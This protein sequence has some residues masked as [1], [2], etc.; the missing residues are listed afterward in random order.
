MKLQPCHFLARLIK[1][2]IMRIKVFKVRILEEFLNTDEA[3]I[4]SFLEQ[5]EIVNMNAKFINGNDNYWSIMVYYLIPNE[6]KVSDQT[7]KDSD[8]NLTKEQKVIYE[9]LKSWR[10]KK[11]R[12]LD[13][14]SFYICHNSH[15]IS[16]TK[17]LP[18]SLKDFSEIKGF[19]N[20]RRDKYGEEILDV[21]MNV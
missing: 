4:N 17:S 19:G 2:L 3:L 16:I 15:L 21:L 11:A 13:V 9:A 5:H 14:P 7:F 10:L 18:V 20:V 12:E 6:K 1:I 8:E